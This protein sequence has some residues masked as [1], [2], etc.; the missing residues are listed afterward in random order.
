MSHLTV[1]DTDIQAPNLPVI[2][3]CAILNAIWG[4]KYTVQ[5]L[6]Q[7]TSLGGSYIRYYCEQ[8]RNA[9]RS[10]GTS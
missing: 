3:R 10:K 4:S 2:T 8:S 9:L 6:I 1:L 5:Q 7:D